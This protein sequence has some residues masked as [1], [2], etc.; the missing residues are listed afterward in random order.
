MMRDQNRI[1]DFILD[2]L[3][4]EA[5]SEEPV[6]LERWLEES[7]ENRKLF[8]VYREI[9]LGT[10]KYDS[11][12]NV[13]VSKMFDEFKK[14]RIVKTKKSGYSWIWKSAVG[15]ASLAVVLG[16]SYNLGEKNVKESFSDIVIESP[17]GS[18]T[19]VMLPDSTEVWL[20][21]GSK[22]CYSQGFGVN[23]RKISFSGEGHFN[24][25][26]NPQKPFSIN[27]SELELTVLGTKFNFSN[28]E[29]DLEIVVTLEE[30]RVAIANK[31]SG[32]KESFLDPDF[33]YILD[34][35][36]GKDKIKS[37]RAM[38]S[39]LWI[40]GRLLFDDESLSDIAKELER[41]YNVNITIVG[42]KLKESRFYGD[43][44]RDE[45]GIDDILEALIN[46]GRLNGYRK[47]KNITLY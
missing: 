24:V 39:K 37:V 9:W 11:L 44:V 41:C 8:K 43:F 13:D 28:Y 29:E 10:G 23:D 19:R 33:S 20:N 21:S 12:D 26:K 47:G 15:F 16:L 35:R 34:K 25:V 17:F 38:D 6:E 3:S 14:G 1:P 45:V 7:E 5:G 46:T 4:G 22:I 30:G 42:D 31:M 32:C 27:T 18:Q 40:E 2:Y 36:T